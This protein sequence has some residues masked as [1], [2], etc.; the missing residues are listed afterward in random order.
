MFFLGL[1]EI[2]RGILN[3]SAYL[4]FTDLLEGVI[5]LGI[6][7]NC[8]KTYCLNDLLF[9]FTANLSQPAL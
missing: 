6:L 4:P 1:G 8:A 2:D 9:L 5:L 3:I 7:L